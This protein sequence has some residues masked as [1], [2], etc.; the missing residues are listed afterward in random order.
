MI[1]TGKRIEDFQK[2]IFHWWKFHKRD[3]PWRHTHDPYK[4]LVSEVMLQQTQV[5]RVIPKYREFIQRYPTA[6]SLAKAST[7]DILRIWKGMGYNRRAL[8]LKKAAEIGKF[9]KNEKKL[10]NL[11]G[12]GKYTARAILVFAYKQD[13]SLV[14]TNIRQIITHFFFQDTPQKESVIADM[15]DKLLPR[16]KSWDWHQALMDYGSSELKKNSRIIK[17]QKKFIGSNR[18][19]RGK[20]MDILR[21]GP[22]REHTIVKDFSQSIIEGL[23][24]DGLIMRSHGN[25]LLPD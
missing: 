12:I 19:F 8:Y 13:V 22:V 16:G 3:L 18:Y 14:D 24:K 21:K 7:A 1:L 9:P 17:K 10:A 11:P 6:N 23:E 5:L 2:Y 25:V 20:L 15:A 4:I